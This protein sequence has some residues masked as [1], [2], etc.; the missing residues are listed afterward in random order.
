MNTL[1]SSVSSPAV[2]QFCFTV[3]FQRVSATRF[4][5]RNGYPDMGKY[6]LWFQQRMVLEL[7]TPHLLPVLDDRID[8]KPAPPLPSQQS[9]RSTDPVTTPRRDPDPSICLAIGA[10][11]ADDG[12]RHCSVERQ[13]LVMKDPGI[14]CAVHVRGLCWPMQHGIHVDSDLPASQAKP[15]SICLPHA[16]S[17]FSLSI[18]GSGSDQHGAKKRDL[19]PW[20]PQVCYMLDYWRLETELLR[21]MQW[22]IYQ[23]R[24]GV[25]LH[26]ASLESLSPAIQRY[27]L[28]IASHQNQDRPSAAQ[29]RRTKIGSNAASRHSVGN[30]PSFAGMDFKQE[31]ESGRSSSLDTAKAKT[32]MAGNHD[33][34][35]EAQIIEVDPDDDQDEIGNRGSGG[36]GGT[37]YSHF[38]DARSDETVSCRDIQES[39]AN[40]GLCVLGCIV[41]TVIAIYRCG[42]WSY[43]QCGLDS[44][45]SYDTRTTENRRRGSAGTSLLYDSD[46]D[47]GDRRRRHAGASSTTAGGGKESKR[48]RHGTYAGY[49]AI[50]DQDGGSDDDDCEI[51]S[52]GGRESGD[53]LVRHFGVEMESVQD[54]RN[55]SSQTNPNKHLPL[56][57]YYP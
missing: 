46:E 13:M 6:G 31:F 53:A 14:L 3:Q 54:H 42:S 57:P 43:Q 11:E 17:L 9:W 2:P 34:E 38:P 39:T 29:L 10:V 27:N 26:Q 50:S 32:T 16:R 1:T 47:I 37:S 21:P 44:V 55:R 48:N 45:A 22:Q 30:Q 12:K 52:V 40:G 20:M 5:H 15:I 33:A 23:Q 24:S 18:T 49:E 25:Q 36:F 41:E 35:F 28:G 51:D 8:P 4:I 19:S 56:D 7:Q